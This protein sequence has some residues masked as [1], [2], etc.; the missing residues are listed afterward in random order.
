MFLSVGTLAVVG[1]ECHTDV[2]MLF[3]VI[4]MIRLLLE[5]PENHLRVRFS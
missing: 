5:R 4:R 3:I 2:P 1:I